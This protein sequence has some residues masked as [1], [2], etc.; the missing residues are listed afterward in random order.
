MS[1]VINI[2]SDEEF[3]S[4]MEKASSKVCKS[5]EDI[6]YMYILYLYSVHY[7]CTLYVYTMHYTCTL[8]VRG[9]QPFVVGGPKNWKIKDLLLLRAINLYF[10]ANLPKFFLVLGI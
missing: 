8:Y 7:T 9:R 4:E 2:N 1:G 6:H 3:A 5:D 10:F